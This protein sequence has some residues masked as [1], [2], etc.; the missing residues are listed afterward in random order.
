MTNTKVQNTKSYH[1]KNVF[2]FNS[3]V[4][5]SDLEFEICKLF[6]FYDL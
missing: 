4:F 3:S 2:E 1:L 6:V 5:N